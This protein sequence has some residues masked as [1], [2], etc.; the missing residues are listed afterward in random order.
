MQKP[1]DF[2]V[3]LHRRATDGKVFYV[4]KGTGK[5]A[6]EKS[7][8]RNAYWNRV[9]AKH[10]YI[11]EFYATGLQEWFALE[12]EIQLI[13]YYGR[14]NLCNLT[15]SGEGSSGYIFSK[16]SKIKMSLIKKGKKMTQETKNEMSISRKGKPKSDLAKAAMSIAFKGRIFTEEHK[17]KISKTKTGK[18]MSEESKIKMSISR[19]GIKHSEET[20]NK[21][22]ESRSKAVICD[23]GMI[24]KN[25]VIAVLWLKKNG[26]DRATKSAIYEVCK[27][28][29]KTAY[30]YTWRYEND[31]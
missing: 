23:N 16:E 10:G 27:G 14:E 25:S 20:K 22:V 8:S 19:T 12:L 6:F 3:Y 26:F 15:D 9:V 13:A 4:G 2:Y 21:I 17:Q 7:I 30:G 5:R 11:I 18:K 24:F 1:K 29:R 28:R 31:S